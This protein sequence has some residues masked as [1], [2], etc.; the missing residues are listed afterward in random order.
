LLT[1]LP[2]GLAPLRGI[3]VGVGGTSLE[4]E[5]GVVGLGLPN[6]DV[7]DLE[8][9]K[10]VAGGEDSADEESKNGGDECGEHDGGG[11]VDMNT[12]RAINAVW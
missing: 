8:G 2:R 4:E 6:P 7:C 1:C 12:R 9:R 5:G 11:A 3:G 10:G